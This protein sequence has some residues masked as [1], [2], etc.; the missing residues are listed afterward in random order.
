MAEAKI[1]KNNSQ[2]YGYNYAS[3]ADIAEQGF[4][5]PK[6]RIA[7][8]LQADYIEYFDGT[9][10]QQGAKIVVP[11]MSGSNEAQRYASAVTYARRVTAQL[12]LALACQDDQEIEKQSHGG[13][14]KST[15]T[16]E[17]RTFNLKDAD[18]RIKRATTVEE[19][20]KVYNEAPEKLRQYLKKGCEARVKELK[21]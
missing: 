10:W 15:K 14:A 6:M 4:E 5:I 20:L 18:V 17:S 12:A 13:R 3:L 8:H 16:Q 7:S 11:E 2:G 9:E 19:V 1:V 21:K